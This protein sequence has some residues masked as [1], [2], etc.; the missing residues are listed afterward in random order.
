MFNNENEK[1]VELCPSQASNIYTN[2]ENQHSEFFQH[3]S[4]P[5]PSINKPSLD[6][7]VSVPIYLA[8]SL[9]G[10]YF[11]GSA[12]N[13]T[14]GKNTGAWA[15][16]YN[17][18]HSGVNLYV[19]VWTAT[20]AAKAPFNVQVWFN[21]NTPEMLHEFA[22]VTSANQALCPIPHP[23]VKLQYAS[24]AKGI[25]SGSI[26]IYSRIVPPE[27]TI[28]DDED[29]KFIFP[30]GGSFLISLSYLNIADAAASGRVAFGW[31]EEPI[32]K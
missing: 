3:C 26:K 8:K 12:D 9:E 17:P 29:G 24:N 16:L 1:Y 13:L 18:I 20:N 32:C 15:R 11:I 23:K 31:W 14:F 25:P 27:T 2:A 19:A 7:T 28:A 4:L 30:P 5:Q 22:Q 6:Y 21:N 10:K